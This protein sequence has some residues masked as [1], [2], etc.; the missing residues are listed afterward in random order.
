MS[1]VCFCRRIHFQAFHH[2]QVPGWESH[3]NRAAFGDAAEPHAHSWSLTLWLSGPVD[4]ITG[5]IVDLVEV[6]RVLQ[7]EVT[8]PFHGRHFRDAD[9]Y[10]V[11]RQPT[12][13]V[14]ASYFAKRLQEKLSQ[15]KLTRLRIAEMDDLFAEW[16]P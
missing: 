7:Q 6:D 15:V 11:S 5:M 12:T 3:Q 14:L 10:F 1:E 16:T 13:E 8:E 4:P 2:Y 9:P